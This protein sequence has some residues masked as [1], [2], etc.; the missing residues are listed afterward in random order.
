MSDVLPFPDG[1]YRFLRGVF[2]YSAGVAAMPG[3]EIVR[4]RLARPLAIEPGFAAIRAH[5]ESVRR[6]LT[7]FCACE[8]RSP[9]P[10]TE[11]GF[12]DFNAIYVGTLR[13]WGIFRD[14]TNPVARSNVCP[15]LDPP[16]SPSFY[17]FSYTVPAAPGTRPTFHVAGSGECPEGR[18]NYRD[19]I[20]CR[21]DVS[22]AGMREKARWVTGEM[23][24][25]MGALG[26]AWDAVTTTQLYT[27]HD[28]HPFLAAELVRRGA[29]TG[30]LTWHF[31]RPP[32]VDLEYEMDCRGVAQEIVV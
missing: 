10:F 12:K 18:A 17:A 32:V 21:G 28:V 5:L 3:Y 22:L 19:H 6:P 13:A 29:T 8:L 7:S 24:R 1:G 25:R 27:V 2:P 20:V 14:D 15:E 31:A 23:E 11:Q 26:F 30:G 16:A 9:A 4:A